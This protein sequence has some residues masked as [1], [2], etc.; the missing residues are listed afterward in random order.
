M[1]SLQRLAIPVVALAALALASCDT[2]GASM[3][4]ATLPGQG[5]GVQEFQVKPLPLTFWDRT[6]L[7][8]AIE[9]AAP[10]P[11]EWTQGIHAVPDQPNVLSARWLGGACESHVTA[12]LFDDPGHFTLR[13][14]SSIFPALG[15][16]ALGV[17]RDLR[18]TFR[19]EVSPDDVVMTESEGL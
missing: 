13:I 6:G 4:Q 11:A 1:T 16:V 12:T 10:V 19:R 9:P 5:D 2:I 18:I 17:Q 8:T 15:C 3:L 7:V 14:E